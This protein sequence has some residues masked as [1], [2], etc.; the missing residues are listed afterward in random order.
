MSTPPVTTTSYA[1]LG[2][3]AV[4]PWS[5]YELAQQMDRSLGRVWPRAESKLYEEPKKLVAAGLARATEE[6]VGRRRRTVYRITAKGRRALAE[7]LRTPGTGPTL[8]CEQLLQVFFAENGRKSDTLATL[9]ATERWARERSAESFRVGLEYVQGDGPFPERGAQLDLTARF[10]TDFY[11][12]VGEWARWASSVV[13]LWPE[14][15]REAKG[16]TAIME[17]TLRR[18]ATAAGGAR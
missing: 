7:W 4:R 8:E 6:Y 9:A 2:L 12:F 3:L 14:D 11:A 18:A 10:L 17:E 5:T 13:E 1:L 15:P 16:S